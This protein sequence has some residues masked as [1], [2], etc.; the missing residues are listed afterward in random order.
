MLQKILTLSKTRKILSLLFKQVFGKKI[1]L[2]IQN[3]T[4]TIPIRLFIDDEEVLLSDQIVAHSQP[5]V[6]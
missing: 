6:A 4:I 1:Y 3:N 2:N 5:F